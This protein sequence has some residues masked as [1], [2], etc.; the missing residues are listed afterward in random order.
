VRPHIASRS[1]FLA[2]LL[3]A[4]VSTASAVTVSGTLGPQYGS[5]LVVQT[6]QSNAG[7]LQ[8][9]SAIDFALASQLDLAYGHVSDGVLYLFFTGDLT[10][11]W[12][13]EGQTVWLPLDVF[14]DCARGGQHQLLGNNPNPDVTYDLN[15]M[16]GLTFDT[17]FAADYWL[18][19]GGNIGTWPRLQAYYGTL[20]TAGGGTGAFLGA[21]LT[22]P[23][24]VLSGGTNPYGIQVTLNDANNLDLGSG[25]GPAAAPA[26]PTGIEWAIP[27]AAIGSPAGCIRVSVFV[28]GGGHSSISNQALGPVPPGTCSFVPTGSVDFSAIPGDQFFTVCPAE[29]PARRASW[30]TLKTL[31]R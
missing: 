6:T 14:I 22:G 3:F 24:G 26:V 12:N 13:L 29:T 17:G 20:P 4:F 19:F 11:Y 1:A 5:P 28:S 21:T 15:Q 10:F 9:S 8:Q 31:Y 7:A 16:A 30:G 2:A 27:L 25:C 23:P 18:S